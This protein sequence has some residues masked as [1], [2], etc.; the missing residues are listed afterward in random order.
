MSLKDEAA[1]LLCELLRISPE[2]PNQTVNDLI[3]AIVMLSV[4]EIKRRHPWQQTFFRK[5]P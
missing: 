4:D 2:Q 1:I 5:D 3:D